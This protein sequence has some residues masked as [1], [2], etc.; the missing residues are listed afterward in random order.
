MKLVP[1]LHVPLVLGLV[2]ATALPAAERD[3]NCFDF[4]TTVV[5]PLQPPIPL[6]EGRDNSAF[7]TRP[8]GVSWAASRAVVTMPITSVYE[9]LLDH[10]NVKDMMKTTLVTT[11]LERP[12]YLQ[13]HVVDVVVRLQ[14]LF[15]KL[16]VA[17][18][19]AWAY[20]LVE[21][22]RDAPRKIVVSYQ[23]IAGTRHIERQCGSYVLE[24]REGDATDLSLYDEVKARRRSAED[25]RNMHAGIL[26][27]I[28]VGSGPRAEERGRAARR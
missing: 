2:F 27:N 23:K 12:D 14:A 17:W 26:R 1:W 11:S 16:K 25:T 21:G 13:F 6:L 18:T 9:K 15:L 20:S 3:G 10:R 8:G 22:T 19:E 7:G 24:A 4:R 5:T 28:R